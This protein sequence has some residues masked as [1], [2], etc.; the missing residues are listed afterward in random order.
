MPKSFKIL[1]TQVIESQ[2]SDR[3]NLLQLEKDF[4]D[5]LLETTI[6]K[7]TKLSGARDAVSDIFNFAPETQGAIEYMKVAKEILGAK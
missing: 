2:K 3:F 4:P 1:A 6:S 7:D 5:N